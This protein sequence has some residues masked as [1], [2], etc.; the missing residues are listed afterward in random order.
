VSAGSLQRT[1]RVDGTTVRADLRL[2]A[3]RLVG[4][5]SGADGERRV[6][7]RVHRTTRDEVVVRDAGRRHHA[8]L[9]RHGGTLWVALDGHVYE[10]TVEATSRRGKGPGAEGFTTSPMTGIVAKVAVRPGDRVAEGDLLFVVEAMKMEYAVK[11]PR[12]AVVSA[13][14]HA[15]GDKV[16]VDEPVVTFEAAR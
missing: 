13:V 7:V 9:A 6:D 1:W 4:I 12:E 8:V 15:A 3:D 2:E 10:L 16:K 5:L 14:T 11:A